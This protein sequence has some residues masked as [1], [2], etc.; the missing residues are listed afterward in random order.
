M[1][2]NSIANIKKFHSSF[3]NVHQEKK[4]TLTMKKSIMKNMSLARLY[5]KPTLTSGSLRQRG[6]YEIY[7]EHKSNELN[8]WQQPTILF[9][10][11]E[12]IFKM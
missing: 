10:F 7:L 1:S 3:K 12:Y 8:K 6:Q 9:N 5:N 2:T 11:F 4:E